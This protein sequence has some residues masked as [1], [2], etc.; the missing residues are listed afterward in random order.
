MPVILPRAA[1]R[2]WLGEDEATAD[3]LLALLTPYPAGLMRAYPVS[4]RVS[5]VRNNALDL[6]APLAA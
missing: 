3:E 2:R 4:T 6:L 5:S 1:W